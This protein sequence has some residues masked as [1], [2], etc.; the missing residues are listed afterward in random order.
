[1]NK[2]LKIVFCGATSWKFANWK[3]RAELGIFDGETSLRKVEAKPRREIFSQ[4]VELKEMF[5]PNATLK[6]KNES[7]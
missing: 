3:S 6:E 4:S 2:A 5:N 1:M 7:F